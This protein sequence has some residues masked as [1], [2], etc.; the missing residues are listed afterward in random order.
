MSSPRPT[1]EV[2]N[3]NLSTRVWPNNEKII[4][5]DEGARYSFKLGPCD[6]YWKWPWPSWI[7]LPNK[8]NVKEWI[9]LLDGWVLFVMDPKDK[10]KVE[11]H[12]GQ[13]MPYM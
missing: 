2:E 13:L 8:T 3:L 4:L 12:I 7:G 9:Q 1:I 5:Y 10:D 11:Q 6:N